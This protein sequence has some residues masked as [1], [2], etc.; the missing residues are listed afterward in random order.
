MEKKQNQNK[1]RTRY[2]CRSFKTSQ[3]AYCEYIC[4]RKGQDWGWGGIQPDSDSLF[5]SKDTA[6]SEWSIKVQKY[7]QR[8]HPS[9]A[10]S[11]FSQE[12]HLLVVGQLSLEQFSSIYV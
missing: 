3:Y 4:E 12:Q 11:A 2:E 6:T 7:H 1:T 5:S 10:S 8:Q 9:L